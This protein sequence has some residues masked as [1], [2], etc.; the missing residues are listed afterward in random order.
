MKVVGAVGGGRGREALARLVGHARA[1]VDRIEILVVR[2]VGVV[3][4]NLPRILPLDIGRAVLRQVRL[5]RGRH[6]VERDALE[7]VPV[8]VVMPQDL[9]HI[10]LP[11]AL[12]RVLLQKRLH[13]RHQ[14]RRH[15]RV[16]V[17]I[18]AFLPGG[19]LIRAVLQPLVGCVPPIA[20]ADAGDLQVRQQLGGQVALGKASGERVVVQ[21]R[22][23]FQP[24]QALLDFVLSKLLCKGEG[25]VRHEWRMR[26]GHEVHQA[27]HAEP[28][29]GDAIGLRHPGR[30]DGEHLR[31]DVA[32][33]AVD[34][35]RWRLVGYASG[36]AKVR[37]VRLAEGVQDDVLGRDVSEDEALRV[38]MRQRQGDAGREV[39]DRL[40]IEGPPLRD[41][42]E[43]VAAGQDAQHEEERVVGAEAP[44]AHLAPDALP[45]GLDQGPVL[46][47]WHPLQTEVPSRAAE[48]TGHDGGAE[49]ALVELLVHVKVLLFPR[50]HPRVEVLEELD[51]VIRGE[52]PRD[53]SAAQ[54]AQ[55]RHLLGIVELVPR[56]REAVSRKPLL[57]AVDQHVGALHEPLR[58]PVGVLL[59][60]LLGV[61]K[62]VLVEGL[63]LGA[64]AEVA[65]ERKVPHGLLGQVE[66]LVVV[67]EDP[68]DAVGLRAHRDVVVPELEAL[69]EEE[70]IR[71]VAAGP[72]VVPVFALQEAE[73]AIEAQRRR[74]DVNEVSVPRKRLP[75][76]VEPQLQRLPIGQVEELDAVQLGALRVALLLV[77]SRLL[78]VR[79][80]PRL[81]RHARCPE[82]R[83]ETLEPPLDQ[84]RR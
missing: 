6:G 63:V 83:P 53:A 27:A 25:V 74:Q 43:Q 7:V 57:D 72:G 32:F 60:R 54:Q 9:L 79:G 40:V 15:L 80:F 28:V 78:C 46:R 49:A 41:V 11:E 26:R 73:E 38:E 44:A 56:H 67:Y 16:R 21:D 75:L 14:V 58:V 51:V 68:H 61:L 45:K 59:D 76:L 69:A 71:N 36:E 5:E 47:D 20:D 17:R 77:R 84:R 52:E 37:Q 39:A 2:G 22:D 35:S 18:S 34:A 23:V 66:R 4:R 42:R 12:R 48:A 31:G 1:D 29:G 24:R 55:Q 30:T 19:G 8:E 10:L 65:H 81:E 70:Q 64:P 50:H 62:S 33:V 13:E 82:I 3:G